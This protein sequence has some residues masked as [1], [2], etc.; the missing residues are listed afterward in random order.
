MSQILND[1]GLHADIGTVLIERGFI[2]VERNN[3]LEMYPLL[4]DM[5]R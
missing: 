2:K 5:G 4:R 3:K 1:C